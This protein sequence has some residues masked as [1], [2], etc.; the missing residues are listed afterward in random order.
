MAE[1]VTSTE[2]ANHADYRKRFF[3]LSMNERRSLKFVK[4]SQTPQPYQTE[5]GE[6][7]G[8]CFAPFTYDFTISFA[9]THRSISMK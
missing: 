3:H 6:R 4:S 5:S 1:G 9:R 7:S 8:I 2:F